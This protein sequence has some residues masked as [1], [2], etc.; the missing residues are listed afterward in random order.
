[1]TDVG[2]LL[3][4]YR[5]L[6]KLGQG[7][8][9]SVWR[10]EHVEL[11]T[12]VALKLMDPAIAQHP[13]AAARFK[14]E[15]YS[16]ASLRSRHVVQIIDY[17]VDAGTPY[18]A[19]ELLE[20]ESLGDRLAREPQL[21]P[22]MTAWVLLQ[23]GKA[24]ARAH[25]AGLVHRDLKPDNIF[26]AVDSGDEIVKVLDFGIAK[27]AHNPELGGLQTQTGTM[28]GT[29]YYMS[30]EQASGRRTVDHRTDI[31]A[32]TVITY[33]CL[34]G[35]RP[36]EGNSLGELILAVCSDAAPVPSAAAPVPAGFDEWFARG[37]ARDP[38][39][40][41]QSVAEQMNDLSAICGVAVTGA[42]LAPAATSAPQSNYVVNTVGAPMNTAGVSAPS[43]S[44]HLRPP[45]MA[46]QEYQPPFAGTQG[47][48]ALTIGAPPPARTRKV[49]L[50]GAAA[51]VLA[52]G[53]AGLALR[54]FQGDVAA[55]NGSSAA[56][57]PPPATAADQRDERARA[58][59]LPAAA[60]SA[61]P[62]L[63]PSAQAP[64]ALP[65]EPPAPSASAPRARPA[66]AARVPAVRPKNA[67]GAPK[68]GPPPPTSA[69]TATRP[70]A[71]RVLGF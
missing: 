59:A 43:T 55:T 56:S 11:G 58:A 16:A 4:R 65:E 12:H 60:P 14:R 5:V 66:P 71:E 22:G 47:T 44:Q 30:P 41:Y 33:E 64:S 63:S 37:T 62:P 6:S 1:M 67:G 23:T 42:S 27:S 54:G 20:G 49:L 69:P 3:G 28:L 38:G 13:E 39:L 2:T 31:W 52:A 21:S 57:A 15:A 34:V 53:V 19:M 70:N 26:I 40:R 10:A 25:E 50:V 18:I 24:M 46:T 32:L 48:A 51:V 8:M 29:P 17:G 9:G 36:F 45:V 68:G 61:V 7:G 35:R